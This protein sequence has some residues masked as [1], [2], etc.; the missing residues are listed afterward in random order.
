MDEGL[1]GRRWR[2]GR[3]GVCLQKVGRGA[4]EQGGEIGK[5]DWGK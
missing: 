2:H 1:A 4:G 5:C 3:R